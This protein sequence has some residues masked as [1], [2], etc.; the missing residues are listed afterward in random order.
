MLAAHV[1][2]ML[3]SAGIQ[4]EQ[5]TK[6]MQKNFCVESAQGPLMSPKDIRANGDT[7]GAYY[8]C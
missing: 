6:C 1:I 4:E 8:F 2:N 5:E 7:F 3:C